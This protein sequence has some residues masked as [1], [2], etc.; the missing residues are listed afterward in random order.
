[1]KLLSPAISSL[2]RMRLWRI[3]GWKNNPIDSQREVLQD[4]VTSAQYTEFGRQ[5]KFSE[6]FTIRSFKQAVP[7][8]EY[9]DMKPYIQRIMKGEQNVLW[10]TPIF[11]FA[12]SSG[13]TSEKSKFIPISE[14]SLEDCHYKAAKDVL[15]MYYQYNPDSELLTGKGLV[16]ADASSC[17]RSVALNGPARCDANCHATPRLVHLETECS[18]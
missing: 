2:A 4:L 17:M 14:E 6:L 18:I 16:L 12:K 5:Y 15:T 8:H 13:T 3:E 9:D 7:I 11:W 10:N 1:M